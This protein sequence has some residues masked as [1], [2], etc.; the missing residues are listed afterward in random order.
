MADPSGAA[1][2]SLQVVWAVQENAR[3]VVVK[4]SLG[5]LPFEL[6][7]IT[8]SVPVPIEFE[9]IG[10]YLFHQ[11]QPVLIKGVEEHTVHVQDCGKQLYSG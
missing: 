4:L 11:V 9:V 7:I 1:V 10:E 5:R 2:F 6:V 3:P 8:R